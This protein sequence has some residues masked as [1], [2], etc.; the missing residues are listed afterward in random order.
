M[1]PIKNNKTWSQKFPVSKFINN[2]LWFLYPANWVRPFKLTRFW[3]ILQYSFY[4]SSR[5]RVCIRLH[6]AWAV[7]KR[8]QN[9][10]FIPFGEFIS[11]HKHFL[12][13]IEKSKGGIILSFFE[14][15]KTRFS[16]QEP[17]QST[18]P[19]WKRIWQLHWFNRNK[20]LRKPKEISP[21]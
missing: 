21:R 16:H 4:S 1:C 20:A 5:S 2:D 17:H 19:I 11:G 15:N 13:L 3:V 18:E 10:F 8:N 9:Y 6:R 7:D 12:T 14:S